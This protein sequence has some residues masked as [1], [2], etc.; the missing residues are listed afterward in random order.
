MNRFIPALGAIA[1]LVGSAGPALAASADAPMARIDRACA[2]VGF[3]PG[4][5]NFAQCVLDLRQTLSED[6]NGSRG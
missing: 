2:D 6:A 5:A 1:L 3:A 4:S